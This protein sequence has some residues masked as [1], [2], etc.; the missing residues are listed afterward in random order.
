MGERLLLTDR[1]V[2]R[3][4]TLDGKEHVADWDDNRRQFLRPY[5]KGKRGPTVMALAR[6]SHAITHRR[7]AMEPL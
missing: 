7:T 2:Y 6:L 1:H 3:V 4:R 5:E